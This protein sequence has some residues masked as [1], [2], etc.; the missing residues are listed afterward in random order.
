MARQSAAAKAKALAEQ[1]ITVVEEICG[2]CW[3]GGWPHGAHSASCEHGAYERPDPSAQPADPTPA[4][5]GSDPQTPPSS[6]ETPD[7]SSSDPAE[8]PEA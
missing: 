6:S 5:G 1:A 4:A 3:P 7:T 2:H 8:T